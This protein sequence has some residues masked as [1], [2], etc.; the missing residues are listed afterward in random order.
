MVLL[1]L[2]QTLVC[3]TDTQMDGRTDGWMDKPL[4][5]KVGFS[6]PVACTLEG[7]VVSHTSVP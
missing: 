5:E 3:I 6:P 4:K 7:Q 1:I 2:Q